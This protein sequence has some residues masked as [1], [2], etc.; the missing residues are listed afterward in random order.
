M[1]AVIAGIVLVQVLTFV[2]Y[3]GPLVIIAGLLLGLGGT[4]EVMRRRL[5]SAERMSPPLA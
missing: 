5:G 3:L 4:I 1:L 2:P